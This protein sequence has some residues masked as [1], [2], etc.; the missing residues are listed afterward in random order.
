MFPIHS[1]Q[2]EEKEYKYVNGQLPSLHCVP[3]LFF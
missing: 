2:E 1:L 3:K